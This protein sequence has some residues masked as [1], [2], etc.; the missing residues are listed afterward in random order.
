MPNYI[1]ILQGA[2]LSS[3]FF[4]RHT[5]GLYSK[6]LASFLKYAD[7]VIIGHPCKDSQGIFIINNAFKYISDWFGDNGLNLNPNKCAQC[8][9]SPKGNAFTDPDLKANI[10]GWSVLSVGK[11]SHAAAGSIIKTGT[12]EQAFSL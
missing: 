2:V 3:F 7:D 10:N 11:G 6:S 5:S 9:F 12:N 8:M 4:T 1:G